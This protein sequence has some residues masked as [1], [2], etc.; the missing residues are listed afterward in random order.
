MKTKKKLMIIIGICAVLLVIGGV[1]SGVF[2]AAQVRTSAHEKKLYAENNSA[3]ITETFHDQAN[4]YMEP[5]EPTKTDD[6]T[7]RLRTKRY[8]VNKAQVQ[9]TADKGK[10]WQTA[11]MTFDRHDDTGYFDFWVGKIP[12]QESV[13]YYRFI[14]A[15]DTGS[16]FVDRSLQPD[17]VESGTYSDCWAVSP[18]YHSADWTKGALWYSLSPDAFYNGDIS[19]DVTVSD[20]NDIN[21]WNHPRRT[22]AD[23]YGGDLKGI[24]KKT[25]YIKGLY[26]DAVFMN[27]FNRATQN[28]G[29]GPLYYDMVEPSFGNAQSLKDSL[30]VLHKS[31]FKVGS[32]AVL[33]F[34]PHNSAYYNGDG[35]WPFA[36]A[37]RDENSIWKDMFVFY[38]WPDNVHLSWSGPALDHSSKTLQE[39]LYTTK[40]SFMQYYTAAPF[41]LDAWRIDCGG[42]LYGRTDSGYLNDVQVLSVIKKNL[43]AI[44]PEIFFVSETSSYDSMLSTMWDSQW[45]ISLAKN[46]LNGYIK[47]S[48]SVSSL[49]NGLDGTLGVY[50]R[51]IALS[52]YNLLT[53]HDELRQDAKTPNY[54]IRPAHLILMTYIGSPSIY[55]GEEINLE[56]KNDDGIG[57]D[58]SFYAMEWDESN[59]DRERYN[60][61]KALGELRSKYSA[62]K[63]GAVRDLVLENAQSVYA[64]GRFDDKGT[65]ITV[66]SQNKESTMVD[67][68][69]RLLSVKDGTV[70]TDWFTGKQYTVD[71]NGML[72]LD[73]IPGGSV[74][75]SGKEASKYRSIYTVSNLSRANANVY[76]TD[77]GVFQ[78][79]GEGSL[80]KADK[81]TLAATELYGAGSLYAT[82][83]GSG[84]ALLSVR[85]DATAKAAAYNVTV[86]GDK[87]TV[88]ARKQSGD[89]QESICETKIASGSAVK[90]DRDGNNRFAVFT[91]KTNEDGTVSDE[92]TEVEGSACTIAMEYEAVIGF[93]PLEGSV[94]LKN[95]TAASRKDEVG[96]DNFDTEQGNA[97]LT[98]SDKKNA[99]V[100]NGALTLTAKNGITYANAQSKDNDWTF[101]VK[102]DTA[103]E[104]EGDFAGVWSVSDEEQWVAAGRTVIDGQ[105][106]LFF[107][108]T[109]NGTMQVDAYVK[110]IN[111][112][113]A[114]IVQLQ[115]IGSNY[116]MAYSYDGKS[117]AVMEDL[118]FANFSSEHVGAFV[119]GKATAGFDYVSFGDCVGGG[120]AFNT[121]YA[122]GVVDVDY[123]DA[124]GAMMTEKTVIVSGTWEYGNEGYYQSGQSGVA[125]LGFAAKAYDDFKLNVTLQLEDGK[126]YAAVG[127]GKTEHDS[128][129]NDGFLLK[130]TRD[131]RLTLYKNGVEMSSVTVKKQKD[132]NALRVILEVKNGNIRVY[133]GQNAACALSLDDTGCGKGHVCFYAVNTAARFMNHRLTSLS[134]GWSILTSTNAQR[135]SVFGGVNTIVCK[136][137]TQSSMNKYGAATLL[138]VGTTDFVTS[139]EIN[140]GS[141]TEAGVLVCASEG[142]SKAVDGISLVL[143]KEGNLVLRADG[144][145]VGR[146]TLGEKTE[147][148]TVMLVKKDRLCRVYVKGTAAPVITYEDTVSRGG[149]YQLFATDNA[150][151]FVGFG[152]EDIHNISVEDS[153]L[154]KLWQKGKLYSFAPTTYRENFNN[155]SGWESLTKYHGDHGT[156]EIKDGALSCTVSPNWASGVTIYDRLFSDFNMEFKYRFDD[157]SDNFAGVLLY[158]PRIDD[159]N[160]TA[161]YSLLLYSNGNV[162]LYEAS[163]K[164]FAAQG[165]LE[166]FEVG[167]WNQL[168][169]SSAGNTIKVYQGD[170][171]LI[172]YSNAALN[173]AEG[174]ISFT[175]N[176]TLVSFDDV[177]IDPKK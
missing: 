151:R 167:K 134:S 56:R 147:S 165:K 140:R 78:L 68:E 83:E 81:L 137:Q 75:A 109:T 6:I 122:S 113:S 89:K 143:N 119:S 86:S 88:T 49:K 82:A 130:Y 158:K 149:A 27:P 101:K 175:A 22:L 79:D 95:V 48:T 4:E 58:A 103:V 123:S 55:Y 12:A 102:L 108:R 133:V 160:N 16:Y 24:A 62:L 20:G 37:A 77:T 124:V 177:L 157:S 70:F 162:N 66:A 69:A 52:T 176:R 118:L 110:D 5:L 163:T 84:K 144:T 13:F 14:C 170:K 150:S 28:M 80:G 125:Q 87:L 121:P 1:F 51:P 30:A 34:T 11:D 126:G 40:N 145:E 148:A 73:V 64:F 106:V 65:V 63:T 15:N 46:W 154:Y 104:K 156:W 146:H 159:T 43:Q 57:N 127:F 36:G 138:G 168:R 120:K 111:P 112:Q 171:C 132:E 44:N 98:Y 136:G 116:T 128:D 90:L 155:Q 129:E 35:T 67:V 135:S 61:Y 47:G 94:T 50:P 54:M 39:L 173:G 142:A 23:K 38:Q 139:L 42:W 18:G 174:F 74:F 60:L 41:N 164:Q 97:L 100:E 105:Q 93:A 45:N 96:F 19:G 32:D 172:N 33:T 169:V 72:H 166:N 3:K 26:A 114:V 115:R 107:G 131:D 153:T 92:W 71:E 99:T 17:T 31:G 2:A 152:L 8:N 9:Y 91:A 53:T 7:V 59:W 141:S 117:F 25:E 21:S 161:K 85:Q 29:Y 10:T 76:L